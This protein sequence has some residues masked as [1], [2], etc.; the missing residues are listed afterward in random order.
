MSFARARGRYLAAMGLA[1]VP[2]VVMACKE[3]SQPVGVPLDDAGSVTA[4]TTTTTT[5]TATATTTTTTA[6][7]TAPTTAI[8]TTTATPPTFHMP[9]CP[10]GKFCAPE[11]AKISSKD[12]GASAPYAKCEATTTFPGD[13][14]DSGYRMYRVVSFDKDGTD[15]A[16]ATDPKACCYSW[17]TPC[18]GG[19][20]LRSAERDVAIVAP[21][22]TRGDWC[23]AIDALDVVG[24]SPETRAALAMHWAREAAFEHASVASFARATLDLMAVGAPPELLAE[25]QA[26]ALDEIEHARITFALARAYGG[27]DVGPGKLPAIALASTHTRTLAE[28]ARD[29]FID[30]CEGESIAALAVHEAARRAEDPTVRALLSR[31]ADDEDRHAALAWKTVAWALRAGGADVRDALERAASELRDTGTR[32]C[33]AAVAPASDNALARHGILSDEEQRTLRARAISEV[34]L[35]SVDALLG[36]QTPP[37]RPRTS[38]RNQSKA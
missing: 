31:I 16:R 7:A 26:A 36:A 29:T 14:P 21:T 6:T 4:T 9:T 3:A 34:V 13:S 19:R 28:V 1:T 30:A 27:A 38:R 18:P 37:C 12:A 11:P 17:Y 8:A 23:A 24:L 20:A 33:T 10:N 15:A 32:A 35:P 25:V 22:A 5:T 2:I